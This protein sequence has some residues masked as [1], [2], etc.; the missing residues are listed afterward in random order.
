MSVKY[1][2]TFYSLPLHDVRSHGI[3]VRD[4]PKAEQVAGKYYGCFST[5]GNNSFRGTVVY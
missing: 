1:C 4:A 2:S 3:K 5:T